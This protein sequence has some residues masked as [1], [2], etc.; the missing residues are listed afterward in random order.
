LIADHL[1]QKH[2][3]KL[4]KPPKTISDPV[5]DM[6]LKYTWPGN[7]RELENVLV[8]GILYAKET[9]IRPQDIPINENDLET[10][11]PVPGKN[12]F[13]DLTYKKAKEKVLRDFTHAFVGAKLSMTGGNITQAARQSGMDRQ[14]LQQVMKRFDV[15]AEK[16]K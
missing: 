16:Y 2:C 15:D 6:L 3:R 7:V 1:V 12:D 4:A 11:C 13:L 14:A 9:Q 5:L 8:Q 10:A